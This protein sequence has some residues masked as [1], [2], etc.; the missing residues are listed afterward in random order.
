MFEALVHSN[1]NL[2]STKSGG[3][4]LTTPVSSNKNMLGFT[5]T[6]MVGVVDTTIYANQNY[7]WEKPQLWP[8]PIDTVTLLPKD[9]LDWSKVWTVKQEEVKYH[10]NNFQES[11]YIIPENIKNWPARHSDNNI[12]S[13]MAPFIDWNSNGIYDPENGDYPSFLGDYAAYFISNDLYGENSFPLENKMGIEIQGL[14]YAYENA[15]VSNVIFAKYFVINRSKQDYKP[16][17]FGQYMHLTL[18]NNMDNYVGTDVTRNMVFGYNGDADDEGDFGYGNELPSVACVYLNKS[19]H[20]SNCFNNT[21]T[22][23]EIPKTEVGMHNVMEGLWQNGG[24]KYAK[25]NGIKGSEAE[26]TKYIYPGESESSVSALNWMDKNSGDNPGDRKVLGATKY[27]ELKAG[28]YKQIEFAFVFNKNSNDQIAELQQKVDDCVSFYNKN[29]SV[30]SLELKQEINVYPNPF[31]LTKHNELIVSGLEVYLLDVNG[32]LVE[33]LQN[34]E[35]TEKKFKISCSEKLQ[36]G[37]YYIKAVTYK[38][39]T[40][41]K[42]IVTTN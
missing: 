28:D 33:R 25:A 31:V 16:F 9:A 1:G 22:V 23:R 18:G 42:L 7:T 21:D 5:G 30:S 38:G 8:G 29:L 27:D 12:N 34:V 40:V 26:V 14:L 10:R 3:P 35:N 2:F 37:I 6:W 39:I 13:F 15:Q 36:Q 11:N 24:K 19:L 41:S 20:A 4:Y 32:R 17:Y